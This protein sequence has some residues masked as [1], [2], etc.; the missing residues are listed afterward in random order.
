MEWEPKEIVHHGFAIWVGKGREGDWIASVNALPERGAMATAG[1][2]EGEP[3]SGDF[4]SREA[5]IEAAKRHIDETHR[6]RRQPS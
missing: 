2:G 5:V 4:D 1:P 3:V 6:R